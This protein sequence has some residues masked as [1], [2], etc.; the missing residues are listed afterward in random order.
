MFFVFFKIIDCFEYR[1]FLVIPLY[2]QFISGVE[3]RV[4]K[5]LKYEGGARFECSSHGSFGFCISKGNEK[6][7]TRNLLTSN[8]RRKINKN[9]S[10]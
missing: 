9:K 10:G 6:L 2:A 7:R 3:D 5:L 8:Q 4:K 1:Q